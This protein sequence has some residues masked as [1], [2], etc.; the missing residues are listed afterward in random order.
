[1]SAPDGHTA[2]PRQGPPAA[3]RLPGH[4]ATAAAALAAGLA[5]ERDFPGWLAGVLAAVAASA[6]GPAALTAGRP[7]SWEAAL[8]DQLVRGTLP[9][10]DD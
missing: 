8:V 1:M 7:G 6:G 4:T 9:D 3:S 5:A 10:F 2:E